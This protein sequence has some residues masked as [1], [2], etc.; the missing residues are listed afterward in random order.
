MWRQ[1]FR[2]FKGGHLFLLSPTSVFFEKSTHMTLYQKSLY[3]ICIIANVTSI[4]ADPVLF[5]MPFMCLTFR[6]CAYGMDNLL[7]WTHLVHGVVTHFTS[8][9]YSERQRVV[10]AMKVRAL[11]CIKSMLHCIHFVAVLLRLSLLTPS[12]TRALAGAP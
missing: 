7:F 12:Y 4:Y 11:L 9:Y 6:V 8:V 5:L 10:D 3:W 1:R 2:W